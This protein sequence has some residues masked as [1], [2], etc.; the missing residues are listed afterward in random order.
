MPDQ[1]E[2]SPLLP[3][4]A[5][6]EAA[7]SVVYEVMSPTPQRR[8]PLLDAVIGAEVWVKHENHAPTGAFKVRGGLTYFARLLARDTD[9]RGVVTATRGNHGQSVGFAAR[10]HGVR[11]A[12]VIPTG[13]SE[14]K[15]A[16]MRA[17]GVEL[18]V[19]GHDFDSAAEAATR[20]AAERG[21]HRLPSLHPWLVHG[22]ATY[23]RELF[24]AAPPLD[25]VYV[26]IGL[27]SGIC[28][29]IAS[30]NAL[31]TSTRVIGVVAEGAPALAHSLAAGRVLP[32]EVTTRLADGLA[33]RVPDEEALAVIAAGAE[34]VEV[35][36]D[37]EIAAAM[38]VLFETT[39]N[40][41]EG[42]GAA[43]LAALLRDRA[44]VAGGRVG[45]V[46]SGANVD[47]GTFARAIT[48]R[49]V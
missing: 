9:I 39:H 2:V 27:G 26:P 13:N 20:I 10:R 3:T 7:A 5:Q 30:R 4:A 32:C 31:S 29:T 6:I 28:G 1:R 15:N 22:V 42:A 25:A 18:I 24:L 8:W 45:V 49:D 21:W 46:L 47:A 12:A 33:C 17:L 34:R 41:A 38:A 40:V 43:A 16:A 11:A 35:V 23:A 44:R 48:T 14:D 19:H 37:A 36:S